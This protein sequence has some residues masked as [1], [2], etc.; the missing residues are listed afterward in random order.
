M[1]SSEYLHELLFSRKY[2]E[3]LYVLKKNR[4]HIPKGRSVPNPKQT[5][6]V[7][8]H[9]SKAKKIRYDVGLVILISGVHSATILAY[10]RS[11]FPPSMYFKYFYTHQ[12]NGSLILLHNNGGSLIGK[13]PWCVRVLLMCLYANRIG[14]KMHSVAIILS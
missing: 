12:G 14:G 7:V 4:S 10:D 6:S 13:F 3:H 9:Q 11:K 2:I 8:R 1:Q 5:I